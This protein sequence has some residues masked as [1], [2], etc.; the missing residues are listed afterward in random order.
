MTMCE[1]ASLR[2]IVE[3]LT[4]VS[5]QQARELERFAEHV[6]ASAGHHG[7]AA[8]FGVLA[9]ELSE[10]LVRIRKLVPVEVS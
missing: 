2:P 6:E 3:A 8:E 5:F 1:C 7:H 10:L 4:R 9:G